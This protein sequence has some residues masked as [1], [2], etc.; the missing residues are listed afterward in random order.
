MQPY[1]DSLVGK[2]IVTG[3]DRAHAIRRLR[4]A[5]EE[6]VVEGIRTTIPLQLQLIDDKAFTEV[7]YHTRYVDEWLT[8]RDEGSDAS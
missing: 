4:W 1:Y 3:K 6:F 5:L 2:L 8:R 7:H